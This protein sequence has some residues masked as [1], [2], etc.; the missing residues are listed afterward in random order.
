MT[1]VTLS[2]SE[3]WIYPIKSL[4]GIRLREALLMERGLQLDRRYM[5]LDAKGQFMTQRKISGMALLEVSLGHDH[6]Q[7]RHRH[8]DLTPLILPLEPDLHL[9]NESLQAPIWDDSSLAFLLCKEANEWFSEALEMPCQLVYM[10]ETGDRTATG[11]TS[12]RLQK[13]SF[14]D[15]YPILITGQAS[16]NDLNGRLKD[17]IS[18]RRF[19]PNLV[20][21]G[22][23]PF[24]EDAWHAFKA[25]QNT[26]WAEKPCARCILTTLDPDTAQK[27]KEPLAT[28]ATY[29]K[30]NN[31]ILFGQNLMFEP[32]GSI[33][34]GDRIEILSRK[35]A[36]LVFEY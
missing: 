31:K 14:A 22:G 12:G 19:R 25:G 5:L 33:R 17:P 35:E 23:T 20:F 4:G 3:I 11:T 26:F 32:G 10:P 34:E 6:L 18:M 7:V 2:I 36:P 21:S 30:W 1:E 28:L 27:G 8:K 29:R 9:T 13:V 16:L 24:E 15:S